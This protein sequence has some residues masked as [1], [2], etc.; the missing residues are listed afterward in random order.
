MCARENRGGGAGG[1]LF[2]PQ[3]TIKCERPSFNG[4]DLTSEPYGGDEGKIVC[5]AAV[6]Q[7]R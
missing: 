5:V 4:G 6:L 3:S 1:H 2:Y 7:R